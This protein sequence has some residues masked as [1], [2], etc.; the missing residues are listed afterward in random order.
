[1]ENIVRNPGAPVSESGPGAAG[2]QIG[3]GTERPEQQTEYTRDHS[4]ED[5]GI[6]FLEYKNDKGK[7]IPDIQVADP[8]NA[9]TEDD[10]FQKHKDENNGKNLL[11]VNLRIQDDQRADDFDV[12]EK[13]QAKLPYQQDGAEHSDCDNL[14]YF[15]GR[16]ILI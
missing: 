11:F 12:G 1:M 15:V 7:N 6:Y 8:P 10:S 14:H 4:P 2:Y 16:I 9:E 13:C 5:S 3:N